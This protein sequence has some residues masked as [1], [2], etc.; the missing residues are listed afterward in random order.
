M[1]RFFR[2]V[3]SCCAALLLGYALLFGISMGGSVQFFLHSKI[4]WGSLAAAVFLIVAGWRFPL[5]VNLGIFMVILSMVLVEILLQATAWLG[6]LPGVSTKIKAPFARVYWRAEGCGNGIRNR[7]GWYFPEFDLKAA[8]K[9]AYV[10]DSQVEAVEVSRTQNQG[11]DLQKLLKEKSADWAVLGLGTHGTC[12]AHSMETLEYAWR[13]FQ[14]D[15]AIV[16]VSMGSDVT[17]ASPILNSAPPSQ[18][19]YYDLNANGD[20]VLNPAS[21][22]V[23]SAFDQN[24]EFSHQSPLKTLPVIL[25]SYCMT[26]QTFDSV[27]DYFYTRRR[28]ADL[29]ARGNAETGFNPVP[30]AINPSPEAKRA[31]DVL[32]AQLA[33]CKSICDGHKMKFHVVTVPVFPQAF[34]ETQRGTNWT[35][36]VGDYDYSGPERK[37]VEWA[38]KN[39]IPIVSIGEIVR[40]RNL[41]VDEIRSLYFSNGTG[42][43]TPKGHALCAE[44]V[45]EHFYAPNFR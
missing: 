24:L 36:R 26:L 38:N 32:I 44:A 4:V 7:F 22:V 23:R 29:V 34:Y 9:I 8:H 16:V 3:F 42:H 40:E 43:L 12:P 35:T 37:I 1:S 13:H 11:A 30:F 28:M 31:M 25:Y 15:E 20:L 33:A 45:Y 6:V 17:E 21:V 10:G 39:Q 41:S 5:R 2:I 19:I 14:P 27:R 18:Y